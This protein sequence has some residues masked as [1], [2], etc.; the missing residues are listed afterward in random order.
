M[1]MKWDFGV[2]WRKITS[3]RL[4]AATCVFRL[5]SSTSNGR[6][7]YFCIK[8]GSGSVS[9]K[10]LMKQVLMLKNRKKTTAKYSGKEKR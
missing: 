2:F 5:I 8:S 4:N 9:E 3:R 10:I 1:Y 6:R 7:Q